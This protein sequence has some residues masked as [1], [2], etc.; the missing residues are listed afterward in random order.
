[1]KKLLKGITN[2]TQVM[3][4]N[5]KVPVVVF[6]NNHFFTIPIVLSVILVL[7][8][9]I[10]YKSLAS[11]LFI[12]LVNLVVVISFFISL[13]L[14]IKSWLNISPVLFKRRIIIYGILLRLAG[15]GYLY[16]LTNMYDP[17]S[18]PFEIGS[19]DSYS[20]HSIAVGMVNYMHNSTSDIRFLLNSFIQGDSDTGFPVYLA[21]VYSL[22]GTDPVV[23]RLM[24]C[25]W[26]VWSIFIIMNITRQ[27]YSE[28]HSRI[29]GIIAMLFPSLI[30]FGGMHLKETLVIWMMLFFIET[31]VDTVVGKKVKVFKTIVAV[32]ILIAT[33]RFRTFLFPFL[34]AV[35]SAYFFYYFI[36]PRSKTKFVILGIIF[37]LSIFLSTK[38][39]MNDIA[40]RTQYEQSSGYLTQN[41]NDAAR[42]RTL[43]IDLNYT[44]PF[45]MTGSIVTPFPSF[46]MLEDRQIGIV[47]HFQNELVRN[48]I[49]FFV[50]AGLLFTFKKDF[51]NKSVV[52]FVGLGYIA[53]LALTGT[54]F[55]DRFQVLVLPFMIILMSAGIVEMPPRGIRY[56]Y[57]YAILI[58]IGIFWWNVYKMNLRGLIQ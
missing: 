8:F 3:L 29:A 26:G 44:L 12:I 43:N 9:S 40:I 37:V 46:L 24:N 36:N 28:K 41:L 42:R 48:Y 30:W 50:F 49:Y 23:A 4:M 1:M 22:L 55:Q 38:F 53:I 15:I 20:Y 45:M 14:I 19:A 18:Y 32:F 16:L 7:F 47:I 51:M 6:R 33:L 57:L 25:F 56:F 58:T 54:S 31:L 13:P 21:C 39:L 27:L 17:N 11:P 52:V 10:F 34:L 2:F 35:V 5:N